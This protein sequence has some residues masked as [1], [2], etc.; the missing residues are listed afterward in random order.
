MRQPRTSHEY[1]TQHSDVQ[2]LYGLVGVLDDGKLVPTN[3][4]EFVDARGHDVANADVDVDD[5]HGRLSAH[6]VHVDNDQFVAW[7]A[8]V[9]KASEN[10]REVAT[11]NR[12]RTFRR[13]LF[14]RRGRFEAEALSVDIRHIDD[15]ELLLDR[16]IDVNCDAKRQQNW[17]LRP[18]AHHPG[19]TAFVMAF[20]GVKQHTDA[21]ERISSIQDPRPLC[22]AA[23]QYGSKFEFESELA[24][25][26]L[27][28]MSDRT[29]QSLS[30]GVSLYPQEWAND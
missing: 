15:D 23:K 6:R 25:R 20:N 10:R 7:A 30:C 13:Q 14:G 11:N 22:N 19:W 29:T 24:G 12:R 27:E 16:P 18:A 4:A 21:P 26:R 17:R 28:L 8:H 3:N 2:C 9:T 1:A 5:L